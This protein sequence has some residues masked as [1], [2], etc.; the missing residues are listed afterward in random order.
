MVLTMDVTNVED[1]YLKLMKYM[2]KVKLT[3]FYIHKKKKQE[4]I[5][6]KLFLFEQTVLITRLLSYIFCLPTLVEKAETSPKTKLMSSLAFV[7][8]RKENEK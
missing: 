3:L 2:F 5:N 8:C 4:K 7:S 1:V 6:C